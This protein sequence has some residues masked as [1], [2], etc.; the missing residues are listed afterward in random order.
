M[1]SNEFL[2]KKNLFEYAKVGKDTGK[3]IRQ[4]SDTGR[5]AH[6]GGFF[7]WNSLHMGLFLTLILLDG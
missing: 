4:G 6:M 2:C 5:A 7:T 1:L 3:I